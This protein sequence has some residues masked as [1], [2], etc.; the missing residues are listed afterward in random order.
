MARIKLSKEAKLN[1]KYLQ[2]YKSWKSV[3]CPALKAH[4]HFTNKGWQHIQQE[5]WR[6]RS[7]K[8]ERLKLLST[9]KV[10]LKRT[11]TIQGTRMQAYHDTPHLHYQF[12]AL[13]GGVVVT[14]IVIEDQGRFDFLSVFRV[15]GNK[16]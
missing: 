11:T 5:K 10:I 8:E 12:T 1:R 16:R 7:E 15:S 3:L 14:V 13:I 4:V 2:R 9:A 6:T